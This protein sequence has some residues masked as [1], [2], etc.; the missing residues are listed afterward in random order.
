LCVNRL[1]ILNSD[2]TI[3]FGLKNISSLSN[4][5]KSSTNQ[6]VIV[7]EVRLGEEETS[8]FHMFTTFLSYLKNLIRLKLEI[9]R[10]ILLFLENVEL[11]DINL[12]IDYRQ[13]AN[14]LVLKTDLKNFKFDLD[15]LYFVRLLSF[16]KNSTS[17]LAT[18]LNNFNY[19]IDIKLNNIEIRIKLE[20][21]L[22]MNLMMKSSVIQFSNKLSKKNCKINMLMNIDITNLNKNE[23]VDKIE[24]VLE[25]KILDAVVKIE[26]LKKQR[27]YYL[28]VVMPQLVE[29]NFN[30]L[31][32]IFIPEIL[33][34]MASGNES[35]SIY[36]LIEMKSIK[37]SIVNDL[38]VKCDLL[39]SIR[40]LQHPDLF[41]LAL[42]LSL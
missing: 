26:V 33:V 37:M 29:A 40:C 2:Q 11:S 9:K 8:S 20:H 23:S 34:N 24:L 36:Q 30:S 16:I 18:K 19:Y 12:D 3:Q 1:E 6:L 28:D 42:V 27:K 17:M 31:E 22:L 39:R 4:I 21:D 41:D 10:V 5:D 15:R 7:E 35:N 25:K 38:N 32:D 13:F 14:H